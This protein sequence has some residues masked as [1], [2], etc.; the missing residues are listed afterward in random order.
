MK[1]I[2]DT[3]RMNILDTQRKNIL[4]TQMQLQPSRKEHALEIMSWFPEE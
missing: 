3:Q 4:D 2:L 1:N